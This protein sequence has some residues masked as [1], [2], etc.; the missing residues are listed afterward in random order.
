[1]SESATNDAQRRMCDVCWGMYC[2]PAGV[3]ACPDCQ[4]ATPPAPAQNGVTL[5]EAVQRMYLEMRRCFHAA[6]GVPDRPVGDHTHCGLIHGDVLDAVAA[7]ESDLSAAI[8]ERD[9]VA[10]KLS[11]YIAMAGTQHVVALTDRCNQLVKERDEAQALAKKWASLIAEADGEFKKLRA[12]AAKERAR[13]DE[14]VKAVTDAV[15]GIAFDSGAC[16][17]KDAAVDYY[18]GNSSKAM[19]DLEWYARKAIDLR[20]EVAR[21]GAERDR[22]LGKYG[23][24]YPW[25]DVRTNHYVIELEHEPGKMIRFI[26][27]D[28]G[29]EDRKRAVAARLRITADQMDPQLDAAGRGVTEDVVRAAMAEA[30][31]FKAMGEPG[32]TP[33]KAMT[34]ALLAALP[35][36]NEGESQP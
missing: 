6:Q 18:D 24:T 32:W 20:A 3:T 31:G 10:A 7:L 14:W 12:E 27:L 13:A 33:Q 5:R 17:P 4:A 29:C 15:V 11:A 16:V 35:K 19:R 26:N 8:R 22:A 34:K 36:T 2:L 28:G 23:N 30:F 9:E 1:M 21:L 25:C